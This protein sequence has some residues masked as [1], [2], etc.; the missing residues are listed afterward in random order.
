MKR[1]FLLEDEKLARWLERKAIQ[2]LGLFVVE[3]DSCKQARSVWQE[4]VFD[5]LVCDY[6]LPDGKGRDFVRWARGSGY[7]GPVV[8]LTG[9][10]EELST[11]EEATV[12]LPKP[13]DWDVFSRAITGLLPADHNNT[14]EPEAR[15]SFRGRFRVEMLSGDGSLAEVER[16][17][18]EVSSDWLALD[19]RM[20]G[21]F[22]A[23]L[24]TNL[25]SLAGKLRREG[26]RLV[27]L[28]S[29]GHAEKALLAGELDFA[30]KESSLDVLSRRQAANCERRALLAAVVN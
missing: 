8:Y 21:V 18:R 29:V 5:L 25:L 28:G 6:S 16:L 11:S 12:V 15:R 7:E 9:D 22:S 20:L 27:W 13:L 3:A 17:A 14:A 24:T 4:G 23:D 30:E 2:E 19:G 26:R 10:A 1:V